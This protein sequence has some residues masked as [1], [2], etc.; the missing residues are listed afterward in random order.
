MG[1]RECLPVHV[2]LDATGGNSVDSDLLVTEVDG[3]AADEGLDGTLGS[4]VDG[5]LGDTLG[6]AGD[7]AHQDEA[8]TDLEV[9]VGL[10]GDEELATGVDA[11][12]AVELLG[13]DVLD[14][15]EGDDT[16]VGADDVELAEDLLGLGEHLDDLVDV[17]DVGL[18]GSGVGTGLLDGLD[19]LL[20]GLG[21]VGVV[22][23][24]L[25]TTTAKLHSHLATNATACG[26][27]C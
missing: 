16:G 5:V 26:S 12:D 2:S 23:D 7:G 3:H 19:D 18:D 9:L 20:G 21:A 15:A 13:G 14:M 27:Q 4:G 11:E 10:A 22:D 8:A 1:C 17:G 24:D 6:L 25:G